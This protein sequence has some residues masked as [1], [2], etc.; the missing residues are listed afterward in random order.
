VGGGVG[1]LVHRSWKN[2][3]IDFVNINER[4]AVL[5]LQMERNTRMTLIQVYAPTLEASEKEVDIFYDQLTETS[6]TWHPK[7]KDY[8]LILGDFNSEIRGRKMEE[9]G[10]GY[11]DRQ[12]CVRKGK[13]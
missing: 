4:I 10:G 9:D 12:L 2:R 5:N 1:F 13:E 8:F 11:G 6:E 3:I 7:Y